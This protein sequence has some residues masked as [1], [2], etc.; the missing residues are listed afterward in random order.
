VGVTGLEFSANSLGNSSIF[1]ECAAKCAASPA[2][3]APGDDD[4]DRV[5][6]AWPNLDASAKNAILAIVAGGE[7]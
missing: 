7:Q 4:L 1:S 2:E 3:S 5:V 6:V